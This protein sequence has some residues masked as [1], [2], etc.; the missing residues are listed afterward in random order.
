[1]SITYHASVVSVEEFDQALAEAAE[2]AYLESINHE[3]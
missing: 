2:L 3:R 1:M